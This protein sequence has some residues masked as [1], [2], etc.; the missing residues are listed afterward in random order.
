[1]QCTPYERSTDITGVQ[2]DGCDERDGGYGYPSWG[3]S[4][5]D[6]TGFPK[7]DLQTGIGKHTEKTDGF[8][9][10]FHLFSSCLS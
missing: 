9:K 10:S 5:W 6:P 1:M 2:F 3:K 4:G 7:L 8:L